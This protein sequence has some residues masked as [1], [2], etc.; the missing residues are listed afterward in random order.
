M[1]TSSYR[2]GY[3]GDIEGLRAVAILLVLAAHAGVPWLAGGF[4]GVDVFFVLSGFLITGLLLQE[5]E[6]TGRVAFADFYLRRLRRLMPAS[7]VMIGVTSLVAAA[8]LAPGE[9]LK[10]AGAAATAAL[11]LSN[12]HFAFAKLDYFAAGAETNLF[13]HT[14]SLGVEEQFYLLWPALLLWI[15]AGKRGLGRV[16]H[17]KVAMLCFGLLSFVACVVLTPSFPQLAFYMMPMRAWQFSVGALIWLYFRRDVSGSSAPVPAS[18]AGTVKYW[19]GWLGL[20]LI[21]GA[22]VVFNGAMSYPGW[23]ASVP[24]LGAAAVLAAGFGDTQRGVARL[25]MWRPLQ[26]LGRVSYSWYLWHW[27]VLLLGPAITDL[28]SP[29]ARVGEIC[30]S[31]GLAVI[32]YRY[33]ESPIRHQ[34]FWLKRRRAALWGAVVVMAFVNLLAMQWFTVASIWMQSPEQQRYANAHAD[35]PAIYSMGC[36]DW[37]YSD[38]VR[39]C[40]F[41]SERA[42]HTAVLMGDSIAGQWFPAVAS[43]FDRPGWRLLVLTKS[44]CP[45]VDEPFFYGRIGR[46]YTECSSWRAHAL[47]QVAA[48]KPD[49]VLLSTVSRNGFTQAQWIDGTQRVLG[50]ISPA[51]GHV[52]ILRSTPHLPFDGPDCLAA[53]RGRVSWLNSL[54]VCSAFAKED[55]DQQIFEWLQQAVGRFSNVQM[56]DLNDQVCP[57]Q[58]CSAEQKGEVVFRDSQ[59]LTA[60]F[61]KSLGPALEQRLNLGDDVTRQ[62]GGDAASAH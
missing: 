1:T 53:H 36:D 27:P 41:G 42:I 47:E 44:S 35:A 52:Y 59:H 34:A 38:R 15:L 25:L 30:I 11:W 20:A 55:H 18:T 31:L 45:M 60:S 5:I 16:A 21:V 48:I 7:I 14:W 40:A 33:V 17:L 24:T 2:L 50:T 4:V 26:A 54:Q 28:Y 22:G 32:S 49:V 29:W 37:Y 8:A 9:Q 6:G 3:R 56:I 10:Q 57:Q 23:R 19:M 43:V 39:I 12:I 58:H 46:E 62:E 61:A 13:L 51:S